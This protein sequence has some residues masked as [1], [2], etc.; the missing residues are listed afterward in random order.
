MIRGPAVE[1][2]ERISS[3]NKAWK[4]AGATLPEVPKV[5][6]YCMSQWLPA[7]ARARALLHSAGLVRLLPRSLASRDCRCQTVRATN[8]SERLFICILSLTL[9][10]C[11]A[12]STAYIANRAILYRS[13]KRKASTPACGS[14]RLIGKLLGRSTDPLRRPCA[15]SSRPSVSGAPG[16]RRC[17][18]IGWQQ[19]VAHQELR[20]RRRRQLRRPASSPPPAA[21]SWSSPSSSRVSL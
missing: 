6:W 11:V 20:C 8:L 4:V 18:E 1:R 17:V 9:Q 3:R 13:T 14:V 12:A 10:A 7:R 5:W 16:F 2:S 15:C 21:S 19:P